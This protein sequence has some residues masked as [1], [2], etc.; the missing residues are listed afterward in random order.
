[1]QITKK[2]LLF[3]F[4]TVFCLPIYSHAQNASDQVLPAE[5]NHSQTPPLPLKDLRLFTLIFDHIRRS[6]VEPISDQQ[7]LENA[8]KGMLGEMDPHSAYLDASSFEQLQESTQGEFTGVGIEMGKEN[9]FIKVISPIDDSP[10]QKA[11]IQSG[12]LIIKINQETI[13]GLSINEVSDKIRG[14]AGSAITLTV[15]REDVD[16]PMDITVVR[17]TIKSI[18]VRHRVIEDNIG[19]IRIAQFQKSTGKDFSSAIAKLYKK[20]SDLSGIIIDLRNNP[21]GILQESIKVVDSLIHT[22]TV[23]STKG[24]LDNSNAVYTAK[25]GDETNGLPI[26]VLVNGGS[27]SASEIVA[28]ALQDHKR[29]VIMGTKT[30]GKGS[31]QTILPVSDNKGIKLTTARYFTPDGRSIQAQGIT[32]DIVVKPATITT[33]ST[34]T[35]ISEASLGKHLKNTDQSSPKSTDHQEDEKSSDTIT[36]NQLFEAINLLKGLAILNTQRNNNDQ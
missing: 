25:E 13:Q 29:A 11:G 3:T 19:Y 31:V 12:D 34:E 27:A 2:Y 9:G 10:A 14:E 26:V 22:G 15:I 24:R 4:L 18:S 8:I 33:I 21:G 32:P 17:G 23:V 28:G 30:F 36:D 16:K 35:T 5:A 6:Y 7:L 1:M 20:E